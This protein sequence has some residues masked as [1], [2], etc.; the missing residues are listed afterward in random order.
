MHALPGIDNLVSNCGI[1]RIPCILI[2]ALRVFF[3]RPTY[4]LVGFARWEAVPFPWPENK[5]RHPSNLDV[6][7]VDYSSPGRVGR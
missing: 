2:N 4:F 5:S 3:F 6:F 7:R 1:C